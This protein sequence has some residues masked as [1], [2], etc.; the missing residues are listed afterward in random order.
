MRS[1]AVVALAMTLLGPWGFTQN[2]RRESA[3]AD[4]ERDVKPIFSKNCYPCH[5][6]EKQKSDYRLDVKMSALKGGAIGGAIVPGDGVHSPMVHYVAGA[7]EEIEAFI[8]TFGNAGSLARSSR[9]RNIAVACHHFRISSTE[10][11]APFP[12][13]GSRSG[14]LLCGKD[15]PTLARP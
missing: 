10:E 1:L 4:F 6:P 9:P 12:E 15:F 11:G 3:P 2:S 14:A 7:D 13:R 5:G 8:A